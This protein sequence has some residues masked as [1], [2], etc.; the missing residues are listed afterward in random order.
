MLATL[1]FNTAYINEEP[2][3]KQRGIKLVKLIRFVPRDGELNPHRGIKLLL[4][5]AKNEKQTQQTPDHP[6]PA[7]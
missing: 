4:D 6:K 5:E 7:T 1:V 3:R 2:R